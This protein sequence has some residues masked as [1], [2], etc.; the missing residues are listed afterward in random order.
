MKFTSVL[1]S[2][3]MASVAYSAVVAPTKSTA[4][5]VEK[6]TQYTIQGL[7]SELIT[8]GIFDTASLFTN[9]LKG[10]ILTQTD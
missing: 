3:L 6:R 4:I 2:T 10:G 1:A 8:H 9:I 7:A 5:E